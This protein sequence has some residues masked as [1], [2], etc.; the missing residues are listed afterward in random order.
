M[1]T[2]GPGNFDK[3]MAGDYFQHS[4]ILPLFAPVREYFMRK[5]S[6]E[7]ALSEEEFYDSIEAR[8]FD[9]GEERIMPTLDALITLCER[10]NGQLAVRPETAEK[11]KENHLQLYDL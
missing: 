11:W 1:G 10:Y 9:S 6:E 7:P 3:D 8:K 5:I 4:I 2:W